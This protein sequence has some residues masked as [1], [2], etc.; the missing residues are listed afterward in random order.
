MRI[1]IG[2]D[3]HKFSKN[4]KLILGGVE[5]KYDLGLLGHS[6]ADVLI[7]AICDA[8]LGACGESD[9]GVH[10]QNTDPKYKNISS[11]EILKL[12][13]NIVENK[14]YKIVNIDSVVIAEEPKI[15]K[16]IPEMKKKLNEVLNIDEKNIGIK[17]T[18]NETLGSIGRVEGICAQAIALID[19]SK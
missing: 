14:K 16:Y 8:L 4:R 1:G 6:D 2:Y 3:I 19:V 11:L 15:N 12:V 7:H 5:I 17:A 10:F 9:I 18:T 13:K